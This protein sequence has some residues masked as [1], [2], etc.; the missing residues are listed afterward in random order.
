MSPPTDREE[1]WQV[2]ILPPRSHP[3]QEDHDGFVNKHVVV[4]LLAWGGNVDASFIVDRGMAYRYMVKYASKG[5]SRGKEAQKML[6][7][8]VN[9]AHALPEDD[10]QSM[11]T[12]LKRAMMR[13]TTRRDMGV[14]EVMHNLLQMDSVLHNL[15]FANVSTEDKAVELNE[16]GRCATLLEG[17]RFRMQANRWAPSVRNKPT[18]SVLRDMSLAT[19]AAAFYIPK[20]R[21]RQINRI[22]TGVNRVVTFL[23]WGSSNPRGD[24]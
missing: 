16:D 14:Q 17:Y 10:R 12:M 6:T 11:S 4:Q 24:R 22:R 21:A 13:A 8:M 23:P 18:D 5:E 20:T 2:V 1:D 9:A 3:G 15:T 19:F 7:E